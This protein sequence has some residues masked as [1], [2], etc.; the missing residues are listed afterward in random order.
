MITIV[1]GKINS[2]KTTTMLK[3][4]QTHQQGDGF[5]SIKHMNHGDVDFYTMRRL[6]NGEERVLLIHEKSAL[7][8]SPSSVNIGPYHVVQ[9][10]IQWVENEMR[11]MISKKIS[12]LYLDEIGS[13]EL[14]QQGFH[15][16]LVDMLDSSLNLV[17]VIRDRFVDDVIK[18]YNLKNISI[19]HTV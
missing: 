13:L 6:S 2:G 10:T 9:S 8:E 11:D 17:L 16:V 1:T 14:N 15:P 7:F 12:P 18:D 5:V 19:I 3:H 4:Y